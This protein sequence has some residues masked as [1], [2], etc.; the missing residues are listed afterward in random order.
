MEKVEDS[1]PGVLNEE[2][3]NVRR[4]VMCK[5]SHVPSIYKLIPSGEKLGI[6]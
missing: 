6:V 1:K 5:R 3:R 2:N 4:S